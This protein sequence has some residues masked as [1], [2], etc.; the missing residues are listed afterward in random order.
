[1]MVALGTIN[2]F[3]GIVELISF[4]IP[5]IILLSI[6]DFIYDKYPYPKDLK[7]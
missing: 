4:A 1:M 5:R 2:S 7:L 3:S 6:L